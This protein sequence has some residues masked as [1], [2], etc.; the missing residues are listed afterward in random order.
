MKCLLS[1]EVVTKDMGFKLATKKGALDEEL[2]SWEWL[3]GEKG[4]K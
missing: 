3:L 1:C 4:K 2:E